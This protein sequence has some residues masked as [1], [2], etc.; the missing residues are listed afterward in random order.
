MEQHHA[1]LQSP[2]YSEKVQRPHTPKWMHPSTPP[3]LRNVPKPTILLKACSHQRPQQF[4]PR[5]GY[6]NQQPP[7]SEATK[8]LH[9][10]FYFTC[11]G[12]F[13]KILK[14]LEF[15]SIILKILKISKNFP[16]LIECTLKKMK[17]FE[18]L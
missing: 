1:P 8:R 9:P 2:P 18:K 6:T 11:F 17:I 4:Q 5:N 14:C 13:L 10:R 3:M 16:I 7:C 12:N 15:S